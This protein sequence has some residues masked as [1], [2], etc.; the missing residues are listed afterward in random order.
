[1]HVY[2]PVFSGKSG[3]QSISD[4]ERVL[5]A[6][7]INFFSNLKSA[8]FFETF[9]DESV[10]RIEA[11]NFVVGVSS[12]LRSSPRS[13]DLHTPPPPGIGHRE[14]SRG[15]RS[16]KRSVGCSGHGPCRDQVDIDLSEELAAADNEIEGPCDGEQSEQQ[17]EQQERGAL[18]L[19]FIVEEGNTGGYVVL[20]D[21]PDVNVASAVWA[22]HAECARILEKG[23]SELSAADR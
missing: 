18:G 5:K 3:V 16:L 11:S 4:L 10:F 14:G 21:S 13:R 17:Q 6:D 8:G 20:V 12:P 1:M 7:F 22:G 2:L 15:R 19:D 9:L 23:K